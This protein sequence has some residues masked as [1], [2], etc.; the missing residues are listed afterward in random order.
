[1]YFADIYDCGAFLVLEE[2]TVS[3]AVDWVLVLFLNIEI[4][5]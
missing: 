4:G 3:A 2:C 5:V 1:V